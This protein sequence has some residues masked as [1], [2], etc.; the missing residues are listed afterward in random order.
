MGTLWRQLR[1][2][3]EPGLGVKRWLC[4]DAL[5]TALIGLGLAYVMLDIYRA[6]PNSSILA[7]FSLTA[8]PRWARA[9]LFGTA[10]MALLLIGDLPSQPGRCWRPSFARAG[11]SWQ[12]SPSTA[13]WDEARSR[14]HWRRQ[15]IGDAAAGPQRAHG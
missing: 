14:R 2:W 9:L 3:L 11:P 6:Y 13:G 5:G 1:L 4:C 7:P 10:G 15:R 12:A 8:L